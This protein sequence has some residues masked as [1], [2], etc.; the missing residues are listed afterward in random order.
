MKKL[1]IVR[2]AKSSWKYKQV[3]D[4][5]RP[6]K[7][8]GITDAHLI[9]KQLASSIKK[10][11]LFIT[12]SAN[13]A[14]HTALIFCDT[15]SYPLNN[16]QI[17]KQLYSFNDAYLTKTIQGL[18]NR[19][20]SVIVFS[21]DHGINSFVNTFGDKPIAHVPTCGVIGIQFNET[22]WKNIQQGTTFLTAFPKDFK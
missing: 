16:L 22:H 4:M 2:H 13:R 15:F 5:D 20:D 1:Y 12:S 18:D 3:N 21:H 8:R 10:P 11:D 14:L 19:F 7:Q 9:A 17:K 6:L